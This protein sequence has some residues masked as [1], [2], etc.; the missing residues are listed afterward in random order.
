MENIASALDSKFPSLVALIM[1]LMSFPLI[2]LKDQSV[3][4]QC[5]YRNYSEIDM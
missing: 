5:D 4:V 2:A 1:F 3:F